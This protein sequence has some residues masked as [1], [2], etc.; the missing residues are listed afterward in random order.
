MLQQENGHF[1][2]LSHAQLSVIP[3]RVFKSALGSFGSAL[4]I[5][6]SA[7]RSRHISAPIGANVDVP[8]DDFCCTSGC[9]FAHSAFACLINDSLCSHSFFE[10]L[11]L[12]RA[13]KLS[14]WYAP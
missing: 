11:A 10:A 8:P 6:L 4:A 14:W 1:H 9:D 13:L 5:S 7:L 2:L 12:S 3:R